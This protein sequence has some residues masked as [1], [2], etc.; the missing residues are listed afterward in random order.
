MTLKTIS[1]FEESNDNLPDK[2]F[3]YFGNKQR[4]APIVWPLFGE[5][6]VYSEPF[7]GC[8]SMLLKSPY[9]H[10]FEVINDADCYIVNAFRSVKY[11]PDEVKKHLYNPRF[12]MDLHAKHDYLVDHKINFSKEMYRADPKFCDPELAAWWIWGINLWIGSNWCSVNHTTKTKCSQKPLAGNQGL[13]TL[14][15]KPASRNQG[16]LTLSQ[17]PLAGNRKDIIENMVHAVFVRL[18]DTTICYGDFERVLTPSYTTKFGTTAVFM[19]PPY[20]A[21]E[22]V[23]EQN[24]CDGSVWD[25]ARDWFIKNNENTLYRIVLCGEERQWPDSPDSVKK[26]FWNRGAGMNKDR[27]VENRRECIWVSKHCLTPGL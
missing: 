6:K 12:E 19:D 4:I 21:D 3:T 2:L 10:T 20:A 18:V 15:K 27:S 16:L 17:K 7:C 13:L 1:L 8:A 26:I 14:S 11:H 22:D 25:R 24:D 5:T 23:Y 9:K